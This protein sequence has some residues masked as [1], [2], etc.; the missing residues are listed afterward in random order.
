MTW[1]F[2]FFSSIQ[3]WAAVV[4]LALALRFIT[5]SPRVKGAVLL[6]SSAA[7]LLALP[8]F[9][10]FDLMVVTAVTG[11]SFLAARSLCG[12]TE[13]ETRRRWIAAAGI[14]VVL[15]TLCFFKYR[16]IQDALLPP[17]GRERGPADYLFLI[18]VSYFSF[19]AIH[20]VVESYKR[21]IQRVDALDYANYIAFFPSFISG[22]ISRYPQF[23]AQ[24]GPGQPGTLKTDLLL[25][26]ERFVHGLFKKLVLAGLVFPY[27][28]AAP[29]TRIETLTRPQILL[30]LYASALYFYFDF[31]GYSDLA[32][33][34]ARLIG[35]QLPENFDRPFLQRNIRELWS[36]WHISLT[37][38]LVDY[39]YWPIVRR[40]RNV[41]WFR[42]RP[43]VLS[44]LAMTITFV[45]CGMW[46]GEALNF[47]VWGAYHGLGIS[48]VTVYQRQKRTIRIPAVQRY[49]RSP[50]SEVVG[51]V[52]TFHFFA[53]G[54]ALFL[55]DARK[56]R[57]LA[58]VIF[59]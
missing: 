28:L 48:A 29:G 12:P 6:G 52:G 45:A 4:A 25:G 44:T 14:G 49:F 53:A 24:L 7:L 32:I 35:L 59:R 36:H 23:A 13:D 55:L 51:A 56:L 39:V 46:H 42:P 38:W 15:A 17:A 26:G 8:R 33:G 11:C 10:L 2:E 47:I 40:L 1:R 57:A 21:S 5:T 16:F 20:V 41:D 43:L 54:L 22:P 31:A 37:S 3:F 9:G 18:G 58:A 50:A 34:A 27:S 19:K 30:A